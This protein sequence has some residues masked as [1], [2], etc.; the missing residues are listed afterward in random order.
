MSEMDVAYALK[1]R[2]LAIDARDKAIKEM[3]KELSTTREQLAEAQ[4]EMTNR[5]ITLNGLIVLLEDVVSRAR[6]AIPEEYASLLLEA[7]VASPTS[8]E[9]R[10]QNAALGEIAGELAAALKRVR[11]WVISNVDPSKPAEG[12][13][14]D[15]DAAL[16]KAKAAG[17]APEEGL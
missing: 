14:Q 2:E 16:A 8:D 5:T 12:P 9:L 6:A 11:P 3:Q 10:S 17:I 7:A 4:S 1:S 15:L 13:L